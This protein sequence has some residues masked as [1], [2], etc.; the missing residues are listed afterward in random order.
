M[1]ALD[2][3]SLSMADAAVVGPSPQVVSPRDERGTPADAVKAKV[4]AHN[5]PPGARLWTALSR[6]VAQPRCRE[7]QLH[8]GGVPFA[9]ATVECD[10]AA[11]CRPRTARCRLRS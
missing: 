9:Y 8:V 10:D 11:L 3:V 2:S 1:P 6:T 5:I 4:K 7:G